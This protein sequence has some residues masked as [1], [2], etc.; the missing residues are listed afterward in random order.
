MGS[1]QA[2]DHRSFDRA[3]DLLHRLEIAR[4][5]DW[6]ARLDHVHAQPRQLLGDLQLFLCVQRD[7][8][9]L[10]PVT[11]RRVEDQYLGIVGGA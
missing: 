8:G 1:R 7:A 10:L 5:G 3:R 11:Q 2:G 9:R 4:R 6:K